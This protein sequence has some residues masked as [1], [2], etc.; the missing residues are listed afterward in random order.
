MM[1][2]VF[3]IDNEGN[4]NEQR[5]IFSCGAE[6]YKNRFSS[7]FYKFST[8]TDVQHEYSFCTVVNFNSLNVI[9]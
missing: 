1:E 6:N 3:F 9:F 8:N 7:M 2:I 5:F 4:L